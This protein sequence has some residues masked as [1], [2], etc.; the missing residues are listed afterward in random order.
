MERVL[1]TLAIDGMHCGKCVERVRKAI[2][3]VDGAQVE[4]IEIGS[5]TVALDKSRAAQA[6]AAIREAGYQASESA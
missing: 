6:L 5:A 3:R 1:M 4:N 2:E